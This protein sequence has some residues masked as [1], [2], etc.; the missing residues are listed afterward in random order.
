MTRRPI[1][2]AA[3]PHGRTA[4]GSLDQNNS[5]ATR[6][7]MVV[8]AEGTRKLLGN[9]FELQDLGAKELPATVTSFGASST[10]ASPAWTA[11]SASCS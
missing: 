3:E 10:I 9:L 2:S 11:R 7:G 1:N 4:A 6:R 8:I 5:V